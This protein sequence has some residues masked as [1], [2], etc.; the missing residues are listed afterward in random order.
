[1]SETNMSKNKDYGHSSSGYS[2]NTIFGN[3]VTNSEYGIRL[4]ETW[5]S[6]VSE[7]NIVSRNI[8]A[9]N[10]FGNVL[11]LAFYNVIYHNNFIV[12]TSQA[13]NYG[14]NIWDNGCEGNSW[15]DYTV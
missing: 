7:A 5:W 9:G 14:R 12:N 11:N 10:E 3:K 1:M 6:G 4:E 2:N 13:V 15:S 8:M